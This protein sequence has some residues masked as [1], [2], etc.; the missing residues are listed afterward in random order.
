V[1]LQNWTKDNKQTD[2]S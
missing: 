1:Q 2:S